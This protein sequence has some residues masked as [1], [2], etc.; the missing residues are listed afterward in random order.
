[1][2]RRGCNYDAAL[3]EKSPDTGEW[4]VTGQI[5]GAAGECNNHGA[6]LDLEGNV[7]LVRN[8]PTE[9]REYRRNGTAFA[10]VQVGTITPPPG[11]TYTLGEPTLSGNVA[12]VSEGRYFERSGSAWVFRGLVRPLDTPMG[13]KPYGADYRGGL[14]ITKSVA[15]EYHSEPEAYLYLRNSAGLFDHVAV[16]GTYGGATSVDVSGNRAVVS[17]SG[18]FG[19][20]NL[21]FFELPEPLRAPAAIAN[22]FDARDI[23]GWQ[24]EP[25]SQFALVTTPRGIQYRQASLVDK[26]TAFLTN[27]DWSNAQSIEADIIP[28]AIN[29]SSWVGLALRY[30]DANNHYYVTLRNTNQLQ[31]KRMVA[32]EFT[33]LDDVTLPFELNRAY[34]VKFIVNGSR[35]EVYVDGSYRAGASDSALAHGRAALMTFRA[36]ADYDN[37]YAGTTAPFT[38]AFHDWDNYINDPEPNFTELGG[39]W[40]WVERDNGAVALGQLD[41][42]VDARLFVGTP[43]GDQAVETLAAVDSYETSTA[44][45][46]GLLARWVDEHT[47]YYMALRGV[48]RLDIR[49]KANGAITVLKSVPFTVTPGEFH[50]LRFVVVG[51]QL[52][53]YVDDAFVAGAVDNDIRRGKYGLGT[54]HASA[55][56]QTFE[57]QQP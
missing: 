15:D 48:G 49:K 46:V 29:G 45:W 10:W 12:F 25:G 30:I 40:S 56:F 44:G 33:T 37:V 36:R 4:R 27:S 23:S 24:Q 35:L 57:V 19:E 28:R 6:A 31:L 54:S 50:R 2:A 53:A 18:F 16:L 1:M 14:L 26:A 20:I 13:T 34:H 38:L 22:D 9:I 7:A 47:F 39:N 52:H 51:N 21:Q 43:T 5:R 42:T 17:G 8:S 3:F 55:T 32:G 41:N 11:A